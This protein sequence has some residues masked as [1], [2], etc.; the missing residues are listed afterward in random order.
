MPSRVVRLRPI[1]LWGEKWNKERLQRSK[2]NNE[3]A[4]LRGFELKAFSDEER[5]FKSWEQCRVPGLVVGDI[6]R[7]DWPGFVGVDLSSKKRPGNA[8]SGV[9]VDPHTHRR[10]LVDIRFGNWSS[11]ETCEQISIVNALLNPIVIMVED[12]A[13]QEAILDWIAADK[14][15]FS[16]W[17]KV[18]P[19]TTTGGKKSDAEKGLPGLE[20][21]FRREGWV[22]PY[23][24]FEG[25]TPEDPAPRGDWARLDQEFRFYP[26]APSTDG[27]MSVWFARQGIEIY[28]GGLDVTAESLGDV[29]VR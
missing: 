25:A 19:T 26:L 7:R 12:N 27:V 5:T 6:I 8:I 23:S 28:G 21:E 17:M 15:K 11:V 20:V 3:R 13:Y 24:E 18:E 2:E 22:I 14:S 29:N 4:Y 1:P 10:Y 9:K 16:W